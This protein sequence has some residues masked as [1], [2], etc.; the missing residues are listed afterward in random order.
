MASIMVHITHGPES[1]SRVALGFLVARTA[2]AEGHDVTVFLAADAVQLIRDA[3]LDATHGIGTGSLREHYDAIAGG[4]GRFYVSKMS[5][6]A[7]DVTDA[8]LEGKPAQWG[9]PDDLV[10]LLVECDRTLTY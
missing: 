7:R 4:G 8:D 5:S 1:P 2:L 3:T 6:L 10:R 9:K